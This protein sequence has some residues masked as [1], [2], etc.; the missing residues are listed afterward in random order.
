MEGAVTNRLKLPRR[1]SLR[2]GQFRRRKRGCRME[3]IAIVARA[4]A[5]GMLLRSHDLI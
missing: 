2:D 5:A 1:V 3:P 4:T